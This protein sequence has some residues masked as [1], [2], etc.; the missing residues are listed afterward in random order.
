MTNRIQIA[1]AKKDNL[2]KSIDLKKTEIEKKSS[3]I[4][5]LG[6]RIDTHR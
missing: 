2:I 6:E 4:D 5:Q 3:T 1:T